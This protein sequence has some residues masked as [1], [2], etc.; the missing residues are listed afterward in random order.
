MTI[1]S[2]L[3]HSLALVSMLISSTISQ[4]TATDALAAK[5]AINSRRDLDD[6]VKNLKITSQG[7]GLN[8][9]YAANVFDKDSWTLEVTVH[10][11]V[12]M[13]LETELRSDVTDKLLQGWKDSEE[14][15]VEVQEEGKESNLFL[16]L[17]KAGRA[18]LKDVGDND[19]HKDVLRTLF[20]LRQ[21][22]SAATM[23]GFLKKD[24][25]PQ[26]GV[27]LIFSGKS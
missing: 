1:K 27:R 11:V 7:S 9:V 14:E 16:K 21:K 18:D 24:H 26:A 6:D 10:H 3:L 22:L 4:P 15:T 8:R 19:L 17:Q 13:S 25:E 5:T 12:M 23:T 2:F 20:A